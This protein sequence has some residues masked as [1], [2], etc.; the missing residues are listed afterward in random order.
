MVVFIDGQP[1]TREYRRFKI[2]DV[3]GANDFASMAEVL[4]RRFKRKTLLGTVS[5]VA[6]DEIKVADDATLENATN[7]IEMI[8]R[9]LPELRQNVW[10]GGLR[11]CRN[12]VEDCLFELGFYLIQSLPQTNRGLGQHV[13]RIEALEYGIDWLVHGG[14]TQNL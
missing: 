5:D 8:V 4:Q 10:V 2:R 14:Y 9:V 7:F 3:E 13:E 11:E 12:L 6:A 1:A